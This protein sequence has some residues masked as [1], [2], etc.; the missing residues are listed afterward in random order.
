VLPIQFESD[1]YKRKLFQVQLL[2]KIKKQL[3]KTQFYELNHHN[4][5]YSLWDAKNIIDPPRGF[6]VFDISLD[7]NIFQVVFWMQNKN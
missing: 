7:K 2:Y 3:V 5:S 4:L 1:H 6:V